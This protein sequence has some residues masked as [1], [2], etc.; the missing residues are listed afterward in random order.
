MRKPKPRMKRSQYGDVDYAL[1]AK[2]KMEFS[3]AVRD[4]HIN[5]WYVTDGNVF[6]LAEIVQEAL[7]ELHHRIDSLEDRLDEKEEK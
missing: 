4:G 5:N 2:T 1:I 7:I 6:V 3:R